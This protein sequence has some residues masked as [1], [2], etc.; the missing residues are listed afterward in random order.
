[1]LGLALM[2]VAIIYTMYLITYA[3]AVLSPE[4]TKIVKSLMQ[5]IKRTD[6]GNQMAECI[7]GMKN[8]I[9]DY[10]NLST[11]DKRQVVL[12][13]DYLVYAVVLEENKEIIDEIMQTKGEML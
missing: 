6:Y 2:T 11:V 4:G 5:Q 10:S 1:M 3:A 13:E 9:H 7:Y 8:F 12:W